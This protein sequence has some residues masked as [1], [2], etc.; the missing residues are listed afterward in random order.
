MKEEQSS[1]RGDEV[2]DVDRGRRRIGSDPDIGM[3]NNNYI[4]YIG[5]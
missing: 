1:N 5:R 3:D 2:K 4:K